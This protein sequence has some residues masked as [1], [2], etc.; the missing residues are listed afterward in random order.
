[1]KNDCSSQYA[2]VHN[3]TVVDFKMK[4]LWWSLLCFLLSVSIR[5]DTKW[6]EILILVWQSVAI[7]S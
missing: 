6:T 7:I 4:G 5:L 1:M 3:R 2:E